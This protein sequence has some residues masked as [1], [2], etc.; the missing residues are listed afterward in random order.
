M[1]E[2]EDNDEEALTHLATTP[3]IRSG[4]GVLEAGA[5]VNTQALSDIFGCHVETIRRAIEQGHI[6]PPTQMP[7]GKYWTAGF[8]LDHINNQLADELDKKKKEDRR[9]ARLPV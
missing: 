8:L 3:G 7:G 6:P 9:I 4:L 5:L 1:I 2:T